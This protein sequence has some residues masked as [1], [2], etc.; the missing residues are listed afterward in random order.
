MRLWNTP[1]LGT[2]ALKIE[3]I[4]EEDKFS[5]I[6]KLNIRI[7]LTISVSERQALPLAASI[8]TRMFFYFGF[9]DDC[10]GSQNK[11]TGFALSLNELT[12]LIPN[13]FRRPYIL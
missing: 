2:P 3:N 6:I 4:K 12:G 7:I 11:T 5:P 10:P 8:I 1:L 13:L 9:I